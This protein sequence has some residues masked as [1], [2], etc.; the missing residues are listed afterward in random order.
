MRSLDVILL[1]EAD[2]VMVL[3]KGGS[4]GASAG[5]VTL[6]ENILPGHKAARNAIARGDV[7]VKYGHAIGEATRDIR[8][9]E[10][11]HEHN[12]RT[13]LGIDLDLPPWEPR[14]IPK[15]PAA[16]ERY[17]LG[18]PR[19][20]GRPGVRNDLWVIPSVGCVNG[21]IRSAIRAFK[22][23]DWI[24]SVKVLEHPYGCSQ[25]GMDMEMTREILAGLAHN[26]NAAGVLLVGLG[27]ENLTLASL[28]EAVRARGS[29]EGLRSCE[30]QTSPDGALI[31]ALGEL[32][33]QAA[34]ERVKCPV[35]ELLVGVKCGGSDG[36]SG[37]SANPLTGR[38]A[39]WLVAQGG[40]VL[41]T[42]IPEMFGAEEVVLSRIQ[43]RSVYEAFVAADRWFREYFVRHGQPI[44]ENPSPGNKAGGIT[45]LEEKSLGAVEKTGSGVV[46]SVLSYGESAHAH[47]GV[48]IAFAP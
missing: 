35:S 39:D 22:K 9:G 32:A 46:T 17:F 47:S 28:E 23:P 10:W 11:V 6:G 44:Y 41:A 12:V 45:T 29:I 13:R 1:S 27:C 38:F 24:D 3:P 42:E 19:R 16:E 20:S 14:E 7:I 8:P 36:F 33:G 25:L 30:L 5:S 37:L 34:R 4:A 18:Y 48:Q 40:S 43:D 2:N 21:E 26:P 31:G 15:M